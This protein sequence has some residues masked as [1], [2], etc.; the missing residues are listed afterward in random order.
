[1]PEENF[2]KVVYTPRAL[3]R[4]INNVPLPEIFAESELQQAFAGNEFDV[5]FDTGLLVEGVNAIGLA[6]HVSVVL[7]I[8]QKSK[9]QKVVEFE[10]NTKSFTRDTVYVA[11]DENPEDIIPAQ[12]EANIRLWAAIM[13]SSILGEPESAQAELE[14]LRKGIRKKSLRRKIAGGALTAAGISGKIAVMTGRFFVPAAAIVAAQA[15]GFSLSA[16]GRKKGKALQE[17]HLF[18][19]QFE[20]NIVNKMIDLAVALAEEYP[21]INYTVERPEDDVA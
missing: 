6:N 14:K 16:I 9:K 2:E 21:I 12:T 11:I 13:A 3:E 18:S 5:T 19:A 1:M 17:M 10:K 4:N 7:V 8:D 20:E 15:A